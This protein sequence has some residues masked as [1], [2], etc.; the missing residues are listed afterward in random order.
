[1]FLHL[2]FK[3]CYPPKIILCYFPIAAAANHHTFSGLKH[4]DISIYPHSSRSQKAEI[5]V[6]T[7]VPY[8]LRILRIRQI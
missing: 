3:M 2:L 1:M 7:G 6:S 4:T 8:L 5:K